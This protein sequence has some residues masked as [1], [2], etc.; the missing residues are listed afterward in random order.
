[1][2]NYKLA[3]ITLLI[4]LT[5]KLWAHPVSFQ[6]AWSFINES[7]DKTRTMMG[8]YSYRYWLAPSMTYQSIKKDKNS[9][10]KKEFYI[11]GVNI[12]LHRFNRPTSQG[13]IYLSAGYGLEAIEG[14]TTQGAGKVDLDVDW[15]DRKYYVASQYS[16]VIREGSAQDVQIKKFRAGFAPY[17]GDF[18]ELNTWFIL[19]FK[20]MDND[21]IETTPMLR[22][23]Y[24][25]VLWEVGSSLNGSWLFNF[26][27]H[28]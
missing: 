24:K 14:K 3:L 22:F 9:L 18:K 11:P 17:L 1:M 21:P 15:E 25:N 2:K 4:T 28:L 8:T 26:M 5:P 6:G 20:Q 7:T 10:D 16:R 13:N 12:L 27:L 19:Q 23:Y